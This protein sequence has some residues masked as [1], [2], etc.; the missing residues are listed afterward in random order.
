MWDHNNTT[1]GSN[2]RGSDGAA[3]YRSLPAIATPECAPADS[4]STVF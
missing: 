2:T 3:S 1:R 4:L